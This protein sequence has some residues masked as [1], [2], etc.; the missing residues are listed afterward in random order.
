MQHYYHYY[1]CDV[2]LFP[3]PRSLRLLISKRNDLYHTTPWPLTALRF[4]NSWNRRH[5]SS[6]MVTTWLGNKIN[7]RSTWAVPKV[8][9][10]ESV[11]HWCAVTDHEPSVVVGWICRK[12]YGLDRRITFYSKM[13]HF[14]K[15]HCVRALASVAQFVGAPCRRPKGHLFTSWSGHISG[16]WVGS[17]IRDPNKKAAKLMLLSHIDFFPL[18]PPLFLSL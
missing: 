16:L 2:L 15:E 8:G 9:G 18:S 6:Q 12:Y 17:P 13:V 7:F 14:F 3:P 5:C 10:Q 1:L 4:C 11:V